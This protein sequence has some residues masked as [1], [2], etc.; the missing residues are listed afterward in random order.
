MRTFH[1]MSANEYKRKASRTFTWLMNIW[2]VFSVF[3]FS[4]FITSPSAQKPTTK[5]EQAIL[6]RTTEKRSASYITPRLSK[7]VIF[8]FFDAS[9]ALK[10]YNQD[11]KNKFSCCYKESLLFKCLTKA[12]GIQYMPRQSSDHITFLHQ[13]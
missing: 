13:G 12:A 9:F 5:T 10:S 1:S 6:K 2:L 4:G 11:L 3:T 8:Y 7:K